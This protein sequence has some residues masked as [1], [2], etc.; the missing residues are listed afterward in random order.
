MIEPLL[1][2]SSLFLGREMFT[3]TVTN[4][5]KNIYNGIEKII[6]NDN[7]HFKKLLDN[8]DIN[9]K[10]DIIHTFIIDVHKDT[11]IFNDTLTK[12]F[13][14]LELIIKTIETEIEN[15]NGELETHSK[16]WLY[17]YRSSNCERLLNN[18]INHVKILDDRFDL[19]I[20]LIKIN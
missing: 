14:Y 15:I 6:L 19:L 7:T 10:L 11:K 17:K 4:T 2:T 20:K 3:T 8:L 1:V 9:T 5:T 16:K 18:L 12:S 13:K